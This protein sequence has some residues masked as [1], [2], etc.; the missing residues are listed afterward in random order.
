MADT[1]TPISDLLGLTS[2]ALN[3]SVTERLEELGARLQEAM[4]SNLASETEGSGELESSI[5][6]EVTDD[7]GKVT[8]TIYADDYAEYVEHGT[9][10]YN[11]EGNG[12]DTA[13]SY[14]DREG[15]WHTT[16]GMRAHPFIQPA[17]DDILPS[18][19]DMVD[20][21]LNDLGKG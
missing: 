8:L 18:L 4:Q 15:N 16:T 11:D 5:R 2:D 17:L 1:M 13:W 20:D 14:Q 10:Q 12:R 19:D 6:T 21:I 3:A 9:G 7:G